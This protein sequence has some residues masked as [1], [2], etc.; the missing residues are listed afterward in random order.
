MRRGFTRVEIVLVFKPGGRIVGI[1]CENS[2]ET[3]K[4]DSS[5]KETR[6][7]NRPSTII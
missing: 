2:K 6:E 1:S 5:S 7:E 3:R 4:E